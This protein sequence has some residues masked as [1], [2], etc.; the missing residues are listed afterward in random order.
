MSEKVFTEEE[1]EAGLLACADGLLADDPE[2]EA[3]VEARMKADPVARAQVEGWTAI[4]ASIRTAYAATAVEAVPPRL[5][6][7]FGPGRSR[8]LTRRAIYATTAMA[9]ALTIGFVAGREVGMRMHMPQAPDAAILAAPVPSPTP[10]AANPAALASP[11]V[12]PPMPAAE[13]S[14]HE[15]PHMTPYQTPAVAPGDPRG[16]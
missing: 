4:N 9:A 10:S 13:I 2:L 16:S 14:P 6:A 7:A 1:I 11:A 5:L 12:S 8:V 3:V 15:N